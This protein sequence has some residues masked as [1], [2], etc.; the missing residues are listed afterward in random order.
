MILGANAQVNWYN[1]E[2]DCM[3]A[4]GNASIVKERLFEVSDPFTITTCEKCGFITAH[5]KEC[6]ACKGNRVATSN[7]PYA[8][9]LLM[10]ELVAMNLDIRFFASNN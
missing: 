5:P 4:Y 10:S 8:S 7:L 2:R 6:Q 3:I 9:K 1:R